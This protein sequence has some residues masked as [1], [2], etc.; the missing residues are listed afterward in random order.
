MRIIKTV[1]LSVATLAASA[2]ATAEPSNGPHFPWEQQ[3]VRPVIAPGHYPALDWTSLIGAGSAADAARHPER[4]QPIAPA[5]S[6]PNARHNWS[7]T[8]G[9]GAAAALE[10]GPTS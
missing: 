7:A 1:A 5:D 10:S 3:A 6:Q 4:M 2:V 9:T 8:I